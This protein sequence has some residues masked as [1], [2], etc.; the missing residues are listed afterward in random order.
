[1]MDEFEKVVRQKAPAVITGKPLELGGSKGRSYATSQGAFFVLEKY[2]EKNKMGKDLKVAIQGFG[3]AG[4]HL[5]RLMDEAGGYKIVAVS[6]SSGAVY[7]EKGLDIQAAKAHK[8]K[9]KKLK[10]YGKGISNDELLELD[11]DILVPAALGHVIHDENVDKILKEL[12]DFGFLK[13]RHIMRPRVDMVACNIKDTP[14]K[15]C[16]VMV[17]NHLTKLPVYNNEVDDIVGLV[18]Y[19]NLLLNPDAS[20][21]KLTERIDFVPEQKSVESLLEFFRKVHID[22]AIVVDEYGGVA[23]SVSLEDIA[24]ELLGPIEI[25]DDIDLVEEI[26]PNECRMAG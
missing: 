26:G 14:Q 15:A 13:V 19:R 9:T 23:G 1:M 21:E 17:K 25:A 8:D 5:A 24:E 16:Q 10:G 11:V 7:N 12:I 4:Y 2:L 18:Q 22:M 6:D 3:N 20:L